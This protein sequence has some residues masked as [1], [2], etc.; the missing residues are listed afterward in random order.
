MRQ[1]IDLQT[2]KREDQSFK[3]RARVARPPHVAGA[4]TCVFVC[5]CLGVRPWCARGQ[6]PFH[7][8]FTKTEYCHALVAYFEIQFSRCHKPVVFSTSPRARCARRARVRC[9]ASTRPAC[10][11][12]GRRPGTRTGS[13]RCSTLRTCCRCPR[14]RHSRG[15]S[16]AHRT[17]RTRVILILRFARA[18]ES[19]SAA[20]RRVRPCRWSTRLTA[21]TAPPLRSRHS[22]CGDRALRCLHCLVVQ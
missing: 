3:V 4:V 9:V 15:R 1:N 6:V 2:M 11:V 18:V 12:T 20:R 22:G 17:A 10:V 8:T 21:H 7:L 13:R 16:R 14:M 19:F 5:L